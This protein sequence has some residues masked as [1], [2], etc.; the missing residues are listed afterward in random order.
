MDDKRFDE[1]TKTLS[2][3]LGSRRNALRAVVAGVATS[4]GA[5]GT[6]DFAAAK[7]KKNG[8]NNN[9]NNNKKKDK[10]EKICHCPDN[11][12]NNCKTKKVSHKQ[13]KKHLH[14]HP[15]DSKGKCDKGCDDT[16]VECNVNRPSECCSNNCCLDTTSSTGGICATSGGRCS[17]NMP[18]VAIARRP[19]RSAAART[20]AARTAKSAAARLRTRLATAVRPARSAALPPAGAAHQILLPQ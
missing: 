17:A 18:L 7:K 4:L 14:N 19:S 20:P 16:D 11:N 10:K 5:L 2:G 3:G 1:L 12:D 9:K 13:A 15:N 8:K 6:L